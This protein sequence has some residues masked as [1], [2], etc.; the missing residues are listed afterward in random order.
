MKN[1]HLI[2]T[3]KGQR[4]TKTNKGT[5]LFCSVVAKDFIET[6]KDYLGFHL[7]ITNDEQIKVG[8]WFYVKTTNIYG[9]NIVAK[10]LDFGSYCWSEH[11]LTDTTDEKGY[12]PSHCVKIILT[13]DQD[14]I[15]DGVQAIDEEF[16]EWFVKNPSCKSVETMIE[17]KDGYGNW[18]KY[19]K[20]FWDKHSNKPKFGTRYKIIMPQGTLEE[21]AERLTENAYQNDIW[22]E[23]SLKR[24]GYYKGIIEGAKWQQE[25]GLSY[26]EGYN[27]AMMD[28]QKNMYSEEEVIKIVETSRI[29]GLTAEYLIERFKNL[30][31][32]SPHMPII[33]SNPNKTNQPTTNEEN[34]I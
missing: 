12:H 4:I 33:A 28:C 23:G 2:S 18:Y 14:L 9:G 17:Y 8:D 6:R 10:C 5:F 27:D 7:Y 22:E 20:E 26:S 30:K 3:D 31:T 29:T 1:L 15:K 19:D 34:N 25:Q 16:L 11:I 21:V 32:N 24:M 13:T